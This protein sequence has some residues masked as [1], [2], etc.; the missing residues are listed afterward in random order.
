MPEQWRLVG[1]TE[2]LTDWVAEAMPPWWLT[3][4]VVEWL[5]T[6]A[7]DPF[8]HAQ[9]EPGAGG[10]RWYTAVPDAVAGEFTVVLSYGIELDTGVIRCHRI[11]L[12][13]DPPQFDH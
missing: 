11:E 2:C 12:R 3:A 6:L 8:H 9:S 10:E 4:R 7:L 13:D 5:P 1:F